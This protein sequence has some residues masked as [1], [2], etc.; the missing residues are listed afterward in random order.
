[1]SNSN[2]STPVSKASNTA[3]SSSSSKKENFVH[4]LSGASG[5]AVNLFDI[6]KKKH[7][8][9]SSSSSS[10]SAPP[11]SSSTIS[12]Q[13]ANSSNH[14]ASL[15]SNLAISFHKSLSKS[16]EADKD[17]HAKIILKDDEIIK[18]EE[19][20]EK[21]NESSLLTIERE[22][23]ENSLSDLSLNA[24]L[25]LSQSKS[26][27]SNS[28]TPSI[29]QSSSFYEPNASAPNTTANSNTAST[30]KLVSSASLHKITSLFDDILKS[31]L[32]N[33]VVDTASL[34][35]QQLRKRFLTKKKSIDE[36]VRSKLS[37]NKERDSTPAET[38][39]EIAQEIG[40][41]S[42]EG[43]E[44]NL[45]KAQVVKSMP[46][47]HPNEPIVTL[48]EVKTEQS[49]LVDQ[50]QQQQQKN[51]LDLRETL[52]PGLPETSTDSNIDQNLPILTS[53]KSTNK[54]PHKGFFGCY[55]L[56]GLFFILPFAILLPFKFSLWI[57]TFLL[58][59]LCGIL[60]S[61][62]VF[63]LMLK[64]DF[65]KHVLRMFQGKSEIEGQ[66]STAQLKSLL[67]SDVNYKENKNFDG[68]YKGWM[69]E[70]SE[71]YEP[72]NFY[73]NKTRS[74]YL[75]LDGC[76]L[77]LQTTHVRV[78]KRVCSA[79]EQIPVCSFNEQ[80][81]YDLS[82]CDVSLLPQ[83]LVRKRYWSKKYPVCLRGVKLLSTKIA[84]ASNINSNEEQEKEENGQ[85][86]RSTLILF[87]RTDR[88]KEEWFRLFK[89][90]SCRRLLDS[91]HYLKQNKSFVRSPTTNSIQLSTNTSTLRLSKSPSIDSSLSYDTTNEKLVLKIAEESQSNKANKNDD[92]ARNQVAYNSMDQSST[93]SSH[94]N[95]EVS[96]QTESSLFHDS[97]LAFMNTFLIR[98]FADFFTQKQW[99]NLIQNKIQNK[100][101]KI[102]VPYFME[103]LQI[104]GLDLG[105]VIPLIKH[106]SDPWYDEKGLWV[107]LD[108]D[109]S[110]GLQL[111]L[112]T[113]LNLMKLKSTTATP[114]GKNAPKFSYN[115]SAN[116]DEEA[117]IAIIHNEESIVQQQ[118]QSNAI[119]DHQEKKETKRKRNLAIYDS[120]EEDSPES[121]G[122]EYV[123]TGFNDEENKL[124]ETYAVV[125]IFFYFY[126]Y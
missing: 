40:I 126:L 32:A 119:H 23:S 118:E 44:I 98:I 28:K 8:N 125:L 77:R 79:T 31:D 89:K 97:S 13:Q 38:P 17:D 10:S 75:N 57:L 117:S 88:E 33:H 87:A 82:N 25:S 1:M 107:H 78:P 34:E 3:S 37:L 93:T 48:E 69:N 7:L 5:L 122:D 103:E 110:G 90:S 26:A 4:S 101:K 72:E 6:L 85:L 60:F 49:Q 83:G 21:K 123:H 50:S 91:N 121:S 55:Y 51:D 96:T 42:E 35:A 99:I 62:L 67:V 39:T 12:A 47:E 70:L 71:K 81:M 56:I 29:K 59:F 102:N 63:Y 109:Y 104:T 11:A 105:S 2:P 41:Q 84:T 16:H 115:K 68:I 76:M 80:R 114:N 108:L 43:E 18:E 116:S 64:L 65:L 124:I 30:S 46:D 106:A 120:N 66:E 94:N 86:D 61:V 36:S 74:V 100:L 95:N 113:K 24:S 9:T 92:F 22:E 27:H 52:D 19:S 20:E 58:V 15:L 45:Q 73:L 112:A 14:A 111:S 53:T 54:P